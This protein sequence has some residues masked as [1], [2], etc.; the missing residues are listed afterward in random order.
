MQRA[1]R[2][3]PRPAHRYPRGPQPPRARIPPAGEPGAPYPWQNPPPAWLYHRAAPSSRRSDPLHRPYPGRQGDRS[4]TQIP[5]CCNSRAP[6]PDACRIQQFTQAREIGLRFIVEI[7]TQFRCA[8][9]ETL[10]LRVLA[11]ENA[12]RVAVQATT[13]VVVQRVHMLAQVSGECLAKPR[14]RRAT[15]DRV[16]LQF[17]AFLD[18]QLAPQPRGHQYQLGIDIGGRNPECLHANLVKLP[19]TPFLRPLVAEHGPAIPESAGHAKQVVLEC[20]AG[21]AGSTLRA[22]RHAVAVTVLEAVHLLL[23]DVCHL[24]DR[25]PEERGFLYDGE[26]DLAV[27]VRLQHARD[28]SLEILPTSRFPREKVM[29][30]PNRFDIVHVVSANRCMSGLRSR[31]QARFFFGS[32][33]LQH[34]SSFAYNLFQV[35]DKI[36]V[37]H[38][39]VRFSRHVDQV[40]GAGSRETHIC[41]ARL[42][43]AVDDTPYHRHVHRR[44]HILEALFQRIYGRYDIEI[45]ARTTRAGDEIDTV[46]PQIEAFENIKPDF[47]FLHRIGRQRHAQCIPDAV[48]QQHA[49]TD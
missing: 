2:R 9:E 46:G 23:D 45:L 12:Q 11:V 42:T 34:C 37:A 10:G 32:R 5:S 7:R 6:A 20:G 15:A 13:T 17:Q 26:P 29:H 3:P 40:V 8:V 16:E 33:L 14:S 49:E 24:A 44:A 43:G 39:V 41:L 21:T 48:H 1:Q 4:P 22:Q 28:T 18:T 30:P 36:V 25:A 38:L 19:L 35:I 31:D 27:A 47:H